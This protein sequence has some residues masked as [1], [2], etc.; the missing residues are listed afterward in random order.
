M[1]PRTLISLGSVL[2]AIG[3]ALG[4]FAA[5]GLDKQLAA[6]GLDSA[7]VELRVETFDTAVRYHLIHAI[8]LVL[9]GLVAEKR[10]SKAATVAAGLFVVGILLFSG[11]LYLYVLSG[12]S[13][14]GAIVP[15]G[16]I[17]MIAAWSALAF[18]GWKR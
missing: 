11:L 9:A 2:A 10:A 8:G 17:C 18:A 5:H 3:V 1:L 6:T 15:L 7:A 16:G 13:W 14:L 4:A 12:V